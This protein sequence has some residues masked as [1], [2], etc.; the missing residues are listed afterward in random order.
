MT[1]NFKQVTLKGVP[2]SARVIEYFGEILSKYLRKIFK[3][4]FLF[5]F[6]DFLVKVTGSYPARSR[7][8]PHI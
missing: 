5:L 1:I 2:L 8:S 6:T 4:N 7:C 3:K